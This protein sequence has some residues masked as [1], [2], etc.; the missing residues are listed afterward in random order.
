MR[1]GRSVGTPSSDTRSWDAG[2][3]LR[4]PGEE[5]GAFFALLGA[6]FAFGRGGAATSPFFLL[7]AGAGARAGA[8]PTL[9]GR[10][11]AMDGEQ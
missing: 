9:T 10:F 5:V 6:A 7:T 11:F 4:A 3:A 2:G 8:L 1:T